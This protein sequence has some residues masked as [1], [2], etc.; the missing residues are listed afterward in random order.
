MTKVDPDKK[1]EITIPEIN[2]LIHEPARLRL[3]AELYVVESTDFVFLKR[4]TGLT[5]GNL[6]SHMNKLE[7]EDYIKV[8]KEFVNKKPRTIFQ[9]TEKGREAFESYK[10]NM[11]EV[12]GG[13]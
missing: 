9:L 6:S 1:D 2:K 10:Q 3:M 7:G 5:W 11:K 4:R 8:E 13:I 12:L